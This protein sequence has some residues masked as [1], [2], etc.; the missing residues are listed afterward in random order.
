MATPVYLEIGTKRTF[1]CAVE[2]SGWCRSGR[3]EP[4]ALATLADYADR[5]SAALALAGL[6]LPRGATRFE[7]VERRSGGGGTDFGALEKPCALDD[8]PLRAADARRLAAIVEA[9]WQALDDAAATSAPVLR[10]GPRGGG[11]DR[12]QI[13][14]HVHDAET[15][16]FRMV[17]LPGADRDA[18]VAALR[19][20]RAPC[21]ERERGQPWPWRYAARRVAWHA[22]DHAW[23]IED[24]D[25][26]RD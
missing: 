9:S 10:K 4:S 5:Y 14:D 23:E 25:P 16:Y 21:P 8:R 22:L 6:R 13:V 1:A 24:K 2:W 18:F 11:R 3:D 17:G 12:D 26:T 19:A 20:A 15:A 7:V